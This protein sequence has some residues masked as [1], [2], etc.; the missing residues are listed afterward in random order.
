MEKLSIQGGFLV[1]FN[2]HPAK[3]AGTG[4]GRLAPRFG[5]GGG[6]AG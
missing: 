6:F 3:M 5:S 4:K 2:G 1:A